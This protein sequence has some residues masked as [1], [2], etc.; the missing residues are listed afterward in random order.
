MIVIVFGLPGSGKSYFAAQLA[1]KI[2]AD[3]INSDQLRMEMFKIRTYSEQ[4]K[5][6][7]YKAMLGKMKEI[8]SQNKNLVLDATFHKSETRALFLQE[9]EKQDSVFFIEIKADENIIRQRLERHRAYSEADFEIY[10]SIRENWEPLNEPHLI[11]EST[12]ENITDMLEKSLNYLN[13]E[14]DERTNQ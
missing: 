1:K 10:K 3:H 11:L 4:E 9:G 14:D 2:N 13:Q 12:N 8:M 7:V 6:A 5:A